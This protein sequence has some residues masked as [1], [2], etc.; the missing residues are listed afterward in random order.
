[1]KMRRSLLAIGMVLAV[2]GSVGTQAQAQTWPSKPIRL[3]G[4]WTPAARP[5]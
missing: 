5:M 2:L 4:P 1:M 3:F